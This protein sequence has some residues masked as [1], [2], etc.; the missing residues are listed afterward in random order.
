MQNFPGIGRFLIFTGLIFLALGLLIVF[1]EKIPFMGKLPGD[2]RIERK[3]FGF[4]FPVVTC[5]LLSLIIS[6]ILNIF[7]RK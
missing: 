3:N 1:M 2:I 7:S 4:Y 6:L 5:L